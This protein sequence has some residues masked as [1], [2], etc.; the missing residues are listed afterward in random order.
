MLAY[1][2]RDCR[3]GD[4]EIADETTVDDEHRLGRLNRAGFELWEPKERGQLAENVS[5]F[6]L[7]AVSPR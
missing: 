2:I 5:V 6:Q 3:K 7:K 1:K 4:N